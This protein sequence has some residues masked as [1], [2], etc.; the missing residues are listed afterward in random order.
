M[1]DDPIVGRQFCDKHC[2]L[3]G[4][5]F[6]FLSKLFGLQ[7]APWAETWSWLPMRQL[8]NAKAM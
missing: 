1:L 8:Y 2:K 5:R 6:G 4:R 3:A 7:F